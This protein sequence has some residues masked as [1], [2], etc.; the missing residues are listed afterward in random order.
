[1]NNFHI[2]FNALCRAFEKENV[3][4][5]FT[6]IDILKPNDVV[7]SSINQT[8]TD[9][10]N[11]ESDSTT[12]SEESASD[13]SNDSDNIDSNNEIQNNIDNGL[14]NDRVM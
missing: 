3:I 13:S 11:Y 14:N 12:D 10:S 1:M 6:L 8:N 2:C 5:P 7:Y 9:N 4:M